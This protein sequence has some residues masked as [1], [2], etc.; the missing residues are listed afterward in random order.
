MVSNIVII[1]ISFIG[2]EVEHFSCYVCI[3]FPVCSYPAHIWFIFCRAAALYMFF[4]NGICFASNFYEVFL[5]LFS[6]L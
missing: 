2:S 5:T 6:M 4:V 3:F 1:C